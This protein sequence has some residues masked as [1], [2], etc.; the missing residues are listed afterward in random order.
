MNKIILFVVVF[1][2][3]F[4]FSQVSVEGSKLVKDGAR[5]SFSKYEQV[6]QNQEARDYFKKARANKTVGEIFAYTGGFSLGFG[7]GIL[8]SGKKN[9]IYANGTS[10]TKE[11]KDGG[12]AFLAAGAGLI[13]AA[14]PFALAANKNATKA[15]QI[16]NGEST[17]F[18][19]YLKIESAGNGVALSYNF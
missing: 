16:E 18:Q 1:I 12:W 5:Y 7:L 4:A 3:Q 11:S 17:A 2:S 13:G 15:L 19:P 14:I 9:T 8:I 6:F 10:Y